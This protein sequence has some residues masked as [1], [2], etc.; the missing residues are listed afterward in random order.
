MKSKSKINFVD[1]SSESLFINIATTQPT[2]QNNLHTI[3]LKMEDS[4][5]FLSM[6]DDANYFQ[7]EDD[8]NIV[9]NG[10]QPHFLF[11]QKMTSIFLLME[12]D[13]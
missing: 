3:F 11:K 4:L 7:M 6:E 10:R 2:T 12:D 1:D 13:L 9:V 5:N 8:L